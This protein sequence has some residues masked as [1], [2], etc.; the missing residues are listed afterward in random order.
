[1]TRVWLLHENLVRRFEGEVFSGTVI[2]AV[3]CEGDLVR[4]NGIE[5]HVLREELA[6]QAS[7][8]SRSRHVQRKHRD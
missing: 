8:Y 1:M 3:D 2:E 7:S 6:N 4:S 5:A